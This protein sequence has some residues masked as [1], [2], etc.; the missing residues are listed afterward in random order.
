MKLTSRFWAVLVGT[1]L[2]LVIFLM[3]VRNVEDFDPMVAAV[4]WTIGGLILAVTLMR[5]AITRRKKPHHHDHDHDDCDH[6][7]LDMD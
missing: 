1:F 5:A 7:E 2:V 4:I 6:R 3:I